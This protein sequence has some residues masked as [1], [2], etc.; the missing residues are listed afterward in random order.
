MMETVRRVLLVPAFALI[1]G[2]V[3][4]ACSNGSSLAAQIENASPQVVSA[5]GVTCSPR[6]QSMTITGTLTGH[7][8]VPTYARLAATITDSDGYGIGQGEG[9]LELLRDG[10]TRAF[11]F[12]VATARL[13]AHCGV[14]WTFWRAPTGAKVILRG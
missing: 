1:A 7:A 14:G 6:S 10:Q 13:A 9:P 12:T 4:G 2:M 3:V 11:R 8:S 5:A